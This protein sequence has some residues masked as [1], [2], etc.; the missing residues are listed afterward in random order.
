MLIEHHTIFKY[1]QNLLWMNILQTQHC[2]LLWLTEKAILI[3]WSLYWLIF[4]LIDLYIDWSLY[5]LIFILI[6]LYIDWSLYWLI[7]I[8]LYFLWSEIQNSVEKD[9]NRW[10]KR[11]PRKP[12]YT[13]VAGIV[14]AYTLHGLR[15]NVGAAQVFPLGCKFVILPS[16]HIL[17][18]YIHQSF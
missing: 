5:W 6:D 12:L 13:L 18:F 11:L 3:D 17:L 4:I 14:C 10:K 9:I 8:L 2:F 15:L 1:M 16:F 7:F